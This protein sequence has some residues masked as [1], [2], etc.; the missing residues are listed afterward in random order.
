MGLEEFDEAE[1]KRQIEK[2]V[3]MKDGSMEYFFNGGGVK[4]WREE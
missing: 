1:F 2:M 3:V 4:R